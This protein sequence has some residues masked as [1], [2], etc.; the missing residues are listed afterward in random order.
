MT[1]IVA[2]QSLG[3]QEREV[4]RFDKD[5]W[6]SFSAYRSVII[7]GIV[8]TVVA[9][10]VISIPATWLAFEIA[11][12]VIANKLT[13]GDLPV[14]AGFLIQIGGRAVDIGELWIEVQSTVVGIRRVF[15]LMDL[16]SEPMP[17]S[18]AELPPIELFAMHDLHLEYDDGTQ[19]L[20][21]ISLEAKVGQFVAL[22]GP[23]G[24]ESAR[25]FRA[26]PSRWANN[27]S[28]PSSA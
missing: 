10:L 17:E 28:G 27:P 15:A 18:P 25:A 24:P 22:V 16:P 5:S 14:I 26:A 21:G 8:V 1:N 23:A 19:A 13:A 3:G 20:R 6:T 7:L 9:G 4:N 11:D 12:L 2:V